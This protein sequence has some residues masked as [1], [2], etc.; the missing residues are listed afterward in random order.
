MQQRIHSGMAAKQASLLQG[1]VE[2]DGTDVGGQPRKTNRRQD[3]LPGGA[4][5]RG[6]TAGKAAVIGAVERGGNVVAPV[7]SDLLPCHSK[8]LQKAKGVSSISLGGK[9]ILRFF[10]DAIS[11]HQILLITNEYAAYCKATGESYHH[12]VI[13]HSVAY[14]DRSVHNN[15][16]GHHRK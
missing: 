15:T 13:N 2:V 1:I 10:K 12:A 16:I 5:P 3:D 11:A 6:R 9:G 14:L 8:A 7:A 4:A